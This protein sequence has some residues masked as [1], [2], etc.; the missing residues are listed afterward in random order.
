[1]TKHATH[2]EKDYFYAGEFDGNE[3]QTHYAAEFNNV[4]K[5]NLASMPD[6][7]W[8]VGKIGVD[9]RV[10]DIRWSAYILATAYVESS[11]TIRIVKQTKDKKGRVKSHRLKLWRNFAP[12]EEAGH[13]KG[14]KYENPV[15]VLRL[16]NGNVEITE[17][18]GERWTVSAATGHPTPK[19]RGQKLGLDPR[20][21]GDPAYEAADGDAQYYFGRG[22]VQLTWW[23]NYATAGVKLG[24]GMDFLLEPERVDNRD[25]AYEILA[26]GLCTGAI[27]AHGRQLRQYFHGGHTDYVHARDMVNP[28]VAHANKVEVARIAERFEKVLFASRKSLIAVAQK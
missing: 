1:M 24:R 11:H 10:T 21:D 6:L 3:F 23:Y 2:V 18:D 27:F 19:G 13:G 20:K 16:P 22:L 12:V 9:K 28:K 8:L 15:K 7:L 26:T 4:A 5:F 14:R 17:Y 25:V